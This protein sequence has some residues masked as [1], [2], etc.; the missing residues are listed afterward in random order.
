MQTAALLLQEGRTKLPALPCLWS[1]G[2][3]EHPGVKG[4]SLDLLT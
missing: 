1:Q 3:V 4:R 2:Q